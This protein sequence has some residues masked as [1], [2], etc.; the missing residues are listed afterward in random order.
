MKRPVE[1]HQICVVYSI[2][3]WWWKGLMRPPLSRR[4]VRRHF[5]LPTACPGWLCRAEIGPIRGCAGRWR[6]Q[7]S[8]QG[9]FP[10]SFALTQLHTIWLLY[11]PVR[12]GGI[13]DATCVFFFFSRSLSPAR[14]IL[15]VFLKGA[16]NDKYHMAVGT[17]AFI[18]V[19][20]RSCNN[21]H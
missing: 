20:K 6:M 1:M 16:F 15:V 13:K 14:L 4:A 18:S 11:H 17:G 21:V 10:D 5:I 3:W 7:R 2:R 9:H 8:I 12:R 19:Q